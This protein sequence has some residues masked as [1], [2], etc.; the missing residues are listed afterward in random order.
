MC[1]CV[2]VASDAGTEISELTKHS[3]LNFSQTIKSEPDPFEKSSRRSFEEELTMTYG[4][5]V[6]I[7]DILV[8]KQGLG[9]TKKHME[10]F[11]KVL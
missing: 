6:I 7:S 2:C 5:I 8:L 3:I 9:N 4:I 10:F 11:L 1:V